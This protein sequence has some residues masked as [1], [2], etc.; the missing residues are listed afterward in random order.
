ML[1]MTGYNKAVTSSFMCMS[2]DS[3][4]QLEDPRSLFK[5]SGFYQKSLIKWHLRDKKAKHVIGFAVFLR[6]ILWKH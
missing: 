2:V 4:V 1:V 5:G 3:I 6:I